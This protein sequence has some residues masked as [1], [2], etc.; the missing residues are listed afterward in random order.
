MLAGAVLS[1][2]VVAAVF[3]AHHTPLR[4]GLGFL[5]IGLAIVA[6]SGAG[7]W[8]LRRLGQEELRP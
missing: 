4:S 2:A 3:L 5:F 1:V 7:A 6:I 8:W